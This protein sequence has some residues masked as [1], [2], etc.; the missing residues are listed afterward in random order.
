MR[1]SRSPAGCAPGFAHMTKTMQ[2]RKAACRAANHTFESDVEIAGSL[3]MCDITPEWCDELQEASRSHSV[4]RRS[5][6]FPGTWR[7]CRAPN[8]DRSNPSLTLIGCSTRAG[9]DDSRLN[10]VPRLTLQR[11]R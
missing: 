6:I 8:V 5:R 3:S 9:Q 7:G 11:R 2:L 1:C 4:G 10:I